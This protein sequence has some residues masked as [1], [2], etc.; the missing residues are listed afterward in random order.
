MPRL[1]LLLIILAASN[2]F[3]Q[4]CSHNFSFQDTLRGSITAERAWWD[5][6]H[7]KLSIEVFPESK[8]IIGS[9]KIT[10]KVIA[11]DSVMQIDLQQPLTIEKV[12]QNEQKLNFKRNGN[13]YF[14]QLIEKQEIG[15]ENTITIHYTGTPT[16][17]KNAPW[18]GGFTWT[19]DNNGID[20]IATSCQGIGASIWWPCKDH[21][22]DE[23]ENGMT[24]IAS[25]PNGLVAIANG[26][27]INEKPERNSTTFTWEVKNPINNYGVNL[28]IG[29]Y[30]NFTE[31]YD[32]L[33]G[34]LDMS[35]WVLSYNLEK[36]KEHFK[37]APRTIEAFEHWMGPYPF[38][39]DSYKLVETPY[40]G[41]E[42]QSSVTYG[43]GF[44]NGYL[45]KDRS[46]TGWG[47][48]GRAHV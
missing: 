12:I 36:A 35:Y 28:N 6:R 9:N 47:K 2:S 8:S 21:M 29:D 24:I 40:L 17:A 33:K 1:I 34:K 4:T 46:Q 39:E 23:P 38:Y 11:S 18:D 16:E 31:Q 14:I 26:R 43:N 15:K 13:A 25:V 48:I 20:F 32:G 44:Q 30:Q 27:L 22:Y 19:K 10:Y 45:G 42:H 37:E 41:M 5:L 7:Y 3:A